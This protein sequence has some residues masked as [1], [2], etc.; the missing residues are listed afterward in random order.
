MSFGYEE[1]KSNR[2]NLE[3]V[4]MAIFYC[5]IKHSLFPTLCIGENH[6]TVIKSE[7]K[8]IKHSLE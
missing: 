2:T 3:Q 5:R 8:N 6:G 4:V 1:G 7:Y